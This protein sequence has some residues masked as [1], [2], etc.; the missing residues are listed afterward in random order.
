MGC[1]PSRREDSRH[2]RFQFLPKADRP[3]AR[4]AARPNTI[5]IEAPG[6]HGFDLQGNW[7][8]NHAAMRLARKASSHAATLRLSRKLFAGGFSD[9]VVNHVLEGGEIGARPALPPHILN[10]GDGWYPY[11]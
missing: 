9:Q 11:V 6:P 1:A 4:S 2:I 3:P 8:K 10:Q 7:V 5:E